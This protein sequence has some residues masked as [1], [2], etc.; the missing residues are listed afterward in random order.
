M[1]RS[2]PLA[3]WCR[4][5]FWLA[6]LVGALWAH[7]EGFVRSLRPSRGRANDF[8]ASWANA[9]DRLDGRPATAAAA[10]TLPRHLGLAEPQEG[11]PPAQ[12]DPRPPSAVLLALPLA[13]LD[14]PEAGL[15]WNLVGLAALGL[16]LGLIVRE[17]GLAYHPLVIVPALALALLCSPLREV[18]AG[19]HLDLL[20]LL[21]L[22]LAW[23]SARRGR[24]GPAGAWLGLAAALRPETAL[25]FLVFAVRRET[26][27]LATGALS[28]G[29][30]A[31][32]VAVAVGL[33]AWPTYFGEALPRA[34]ACRLDP[35]NLSLAG[36]WGP[37]AVAA[38]L[39]AVL[40][41]R[42]ARRAQGPA[43][44]DVAFGATLLLVAVVGP[45]TW[46]QNLLL[47]A[48]PVALLG[49][50]A[51]PDWRTRWAFR[52][53]LVPLWLAPLP[54]EAVLQGWVTGSEQ[55]TVV[56]LSDLVRQGLPAAALLVLFVG[57]LRLPP[58]AV[59]APAEAAPTTP[60][61]SWAAWAGAVLSPGRAALALSALAA[62]VEI[63]LLR[64]APGTRQ[65]DGYLFFLGLLVPVWFW[66]TAAWLAWPLLL[67]LRDRT[68]AW[69]ALP[70]RLA[71]GAVAAVAL[72]LFACY[73]ASW[74]LYLR[75]GV[76][77]NLDAVE[78]TL[79][80][81]AARELGPYF[82]KSERAM[83][84]RV[85]GLLLG[86]AILLPFLLPR[87]LAWRW[88]APPG[89]RLRSARWTAWAALTLTLA[90]GVGLVNADE[91]SFRRGRRVE[92]LSNRLNPVVT[93]ACSLYD[94]LFE[95]PIEPVLDVKNLTPLGTDWPSPP[96]PK[97]PPS[98]IFI[99][100]ESLRPGVIHNKELKALG[101]PGPEVTPNLNKL[102]RCGVEFT[103]CY[104]QSTHSDY[105]DVCIVSSLYPLR[106]RRHYY[107]S[108][109]DPWPATR[110]YDL[111]RPLGYATAIISSQNEGWG[112]MDRFY[113][114]D[115]VDLFYDAES[116]WDKA[117]IDPKDSGAFGAVRE[118]GL[119]A[120]R[121]DDGH[122]MD[123]VL[124]WTEAQIK[125][126]KPYFLAL[127]FQDSHFPFDIDGCPDPDKRPFPDCRIDFEASFAD[128][129]KDKAEIVRK[130]Y[131][132]AVQESDK[133]IGRLVEALRKAGTLDNTIIVVY[134]DNGESFHENG[135]VCHAGRPAEPASH[136]AC[137]MYY[138]RGIRPQVDDYPAQLID[139][140]P[141]VHGLLG[142]PVH[143]N[144]QG[145]DLLTPGRRPP[146]A[147]RL[148]F[149]HVENGLSRSDAVWWTEG[150]R[151]WKMIN[152]RATKCQ[153]L[154]DLT[155]D[156]S[157]E[158]DVADQRPDVADRLRRVLFDW[159]KRQLAYYHYPQYYRDY[160]PPQPPR[161]PP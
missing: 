63:V 41:V 8:F 66:L 60:A 94:V 142:W 19:G 152:D 150:V 18:L 71:R 159:R 27:A 48:L 145:T 76:F 82:W 43:A 117:R 3:S 79:R 72:A 64:R 125:S 148:I 6:L 135:V 87:M 16:S 53:V 54:A 7:G 107:Y 128:Y 115:S 97:N 154:Y 45:L 42:A 129:P 44:V 101:I 24:P 17:L 141:T 134:G 85:G 78:F 111:L 21:P 160:Y 127:T 65:P 34:W 4:R 119:R 1:I 104:C 139:I 146:L 62:A 33:D 158:H 69:R 96:L 36:L 12:A 106:K 102:A 116:G 5:A 57:M 90:V 108:T 11:R 15:V 126:D 109:D 70:R 75:T 99:S 91:V 95:E 151:R 130:A 73:A 105:S 38:A 112:N 133:E 31:L 29:A 161:L 122:T 93:L 52:L 56:A 88:A 9:R 114:R 110:I 55:D 22:T 47:L 103:N 156:P 46:P 14:Y 92:A 74:A 144:Y 86:L 37:L 131:Y 51:E 84:F 80:G 147:E 49:R 155:A 59:A 68:A 58:R 25:L 136:I 35:T 132:N 153:Q 124:K 143:P 26:K 149:C 123:V 30:A 40:I 118:G 2:F 32:A 100:F 23:R 140:T 83:L 81:L 10:G 13:G 67:R 61:R 138:P 113:R 157:E 121:L 120:G 39:G 137:V 20:A 89:P 50:A 28:L 98:I 77:V